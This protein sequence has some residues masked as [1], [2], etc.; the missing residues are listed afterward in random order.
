[1]GGLRS[2][3]HRVTPEEQAIYDAVMVRDGGCVAPDLDPGIDPCQGRMTRQHVKD[4]PGGRRITDMDHVLILCQHHHLDGWGTSKRALAMQ[5][6][7]LR[8]GA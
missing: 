7:Y 6:E 4:G 3:P 2:R 8:S 5:R 1:M